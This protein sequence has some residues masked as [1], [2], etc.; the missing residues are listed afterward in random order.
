MQMSHIFPE[1]KVY[2]RVYGP[3]GEM[4]LWNRIT[5]KLTQ[6]EAEGAAWSTWGAPERVLA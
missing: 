2:I 3:S 5:E 4:D 6:S 1:S